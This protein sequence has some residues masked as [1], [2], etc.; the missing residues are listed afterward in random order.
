MITRRG[1]GF[2]LAAVAA[3]FI[4]S[5]TRVGWV[6]MAD[7][8]L[9]GVVILSAV[10]PWLSVYGLSVS[11]EKSIS[12]RGNLGGPVEGDSVDIDLKIQ[13]KW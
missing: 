3:F 7:A 9:W 4:A 10:T 11:R 1:I 2:V 13:N 12:S 6:H 5:A 8:V